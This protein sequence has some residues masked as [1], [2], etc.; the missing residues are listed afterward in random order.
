MLIH[1]SLGRLGEIAVKLIY[2]L[3]LKYKNGNIYTI[4][5]ILIGLEVSHLEIKYFLSLDIHICFS[6][7]Y[8]AFIY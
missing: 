6:R 2:I 3:F 4:R 8:L 5:D 1:C 7:S